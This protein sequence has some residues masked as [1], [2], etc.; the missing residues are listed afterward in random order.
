MENVK[1][2][3]VD[4]SGAKYEKGQLEGI[5]LAEAESNSLIRLRNGLT[6]DEV[7]ANLK[8]EI[9][10]GGPVFIGLDFAFSFPQWYL[11]REHP[12][13]HSAY[14][15]W[16]LAASEGEKWLMGEVWPFWGKK[17]TKYQK[18]PN[19]LEDRLRF[20]QTDKCHRK[21]G[22]K[23]VFQI[24]GTGTVGTGTIRGLPKLS[25]LREAGAAIWPFDVPKPDG[26]NIIEIYP[27]LFYGND[28]KNNMSVSGRN[29]RKDYLEERYPC[30]ERHWRDIMIGSDDAFDAGISA[31]AMSAHAQDLQKLNPATQAPKTLEGKIWSPS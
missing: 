13:I 1:C 30:L 22:I 25:C 19:N 8:K 2:I 24:A 9:K 11:E 26:P 10:A 12:Q 15:L 27:R 28:V 20:R 4:W 23:S 18:R 29:S 31:L 14:D 5:W 16:K 3:A 21:S 17:K 7:T 6:R